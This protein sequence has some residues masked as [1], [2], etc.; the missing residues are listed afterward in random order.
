[1]ARIYFVRH[2]KAAAGFSE[3]PDPGLDAIGRSQA[4]AIAPGLIARAPVELVSSPLR[5]AR[6]TAMPVE[7]GLGQQARIVNEVA[8]IPSPTD[9][10]EAR[11]VWLRARMQENWSDMEP[12]YRVWR[13]GVVDALL[14]FQSDTVVF[15][16]FIAINATVSD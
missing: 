12:E 10:L 7:T 9:D 8:E 16:H 2:G 4:D 1:M 13:Q 15:S 6:E 5:R 14:G 11:G 3:D